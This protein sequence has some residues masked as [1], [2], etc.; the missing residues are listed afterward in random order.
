MR[1]V[2]N[3]H[4]PIRDERTAAR[5][6]AAL[7][8]LLRERAR[9]LAVTAH[10][11]SAT[12]LHAIIAVRRGLATWGLVTPAVKEVRRVRVC[13]LP[14][15]PATVTGL[16]HVRGKVYC[17]LDLQPLVGPAEPLEHDEECLVAM[18]EGPQ[19][20]AGLRIDEVIGASEVFAQDLRHGIDDVSA[21]FVVG[22]TKNLISIIDVPRLL[23][24]PEFTMF[25]R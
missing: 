1:N 25:E 2:H 5:P 13:V 10:E 8:H 6:E 22:V 16:F 20:R 9:K 23:A 18:V 11:D 3:P 21:E 17:A 14:H 7:E 24:R 19:G 4:P 15:T 12:P